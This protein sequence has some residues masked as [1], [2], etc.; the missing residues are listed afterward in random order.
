MKSKYKT[1]HRFS[2]AFSDCLEQCSSLVHLLNKF[3]ITYFCQNRAAYKKW[4]SSAAAIQSFQ[5]ELRLSNGDHRSASAPLLE[6]LL[7]QSSILI[8]RP[9]L[10]SMA[11]VVVAGRSRGDRVAATVL[12]GSSSRCS[13]PMGITRVE[14]GV[15]PQPKP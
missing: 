1:S 10:S 4:A 11:S 14:I 13:S 15:E 7:L 8:P 12:S 9:P 5:L 6:T 3:N 2:A